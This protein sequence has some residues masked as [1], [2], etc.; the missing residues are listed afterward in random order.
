MS[1]E[2]R[3][4]THFADNATLERLHELEQENK[5]LREAL[6]AIAYVDTDGEEVYD[7]L[8]SWCTGVAEQALKG[9]E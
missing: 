8:L 7:Y 6:E 5:R 9:E 3:Q 4:V 1:G 2:E